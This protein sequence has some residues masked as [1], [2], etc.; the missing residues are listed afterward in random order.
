MALALLV[1]VRP[2]LD[3]V[4]DSLNLNPRCTPRAS[5]SE[6][7]PFTR[8][9]LE[10][11]LSAPPPR[12]ATV[13][14]GSKSRANSDSRAARTFANLVPVPLSSLLASNRYRYVMECEAELGQNF[15]MEPTGNTLQRRTPLHA[16]GCSQV[17]VQNSCRRANWRKRE[18]APDASAAKGGDTESPGLLPKVAREGSSHSPTKS[19]GVQ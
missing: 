13:M 14:R 1:L 3:R 15:D 9:R 17:G 2:G 10:P 6:F 16:R 8:L 12:E 18:R 19:R 4:L 7:S 5:P 11:D